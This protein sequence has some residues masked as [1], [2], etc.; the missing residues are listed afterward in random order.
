MHFAPVIIM[1]KIDA[2]LASFN[3]SLSALRKQC[4]KSGFGRR[5]LLQQQQ[6]QQ[7]QHLIATTSPLPH[8]LP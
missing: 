4:Q 5:I 8:C 7:H 1:T 2:L 3:E 6:Q